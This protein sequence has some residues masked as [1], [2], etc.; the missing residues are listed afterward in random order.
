LFA[1][2]EP[3]DAQRNLDLRLR[4]RLRDRRMGDMAHLARAV[5]FVM[6]LP[7]EVGDDLDA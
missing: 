6:G 5:S 3:C 4:G 7:I 2:R 1:L